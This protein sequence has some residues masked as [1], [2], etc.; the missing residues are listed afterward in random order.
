MNEEPFVN[1]EAVQFEGNPESRNDAMALLDRALREQG[2]L[3][4]YGDLS[5]GLQTLTK[6]MAI[7]VKEESNCYSIDISPKDP[8]GGHD[9]SFTIDKQTG[10][11]SDAV[12]GEVLPYPELDCEDSNDPAPSDSD[13]EGK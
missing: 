13:I 7:M 10:K 2:D 11:M 3:G 1:N 5:D 4:V 6:E 9:F 12:I 8:T